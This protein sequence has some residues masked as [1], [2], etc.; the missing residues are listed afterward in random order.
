MAGIPTSIDKATNFTGPVGV[1]REVVIPLSALAST[2]N[3]PGFIA[4]APCF[5]ES[6]KV[7]NKDASPDWTIAVQNLGTDGL[8]TTSL[9]SGTTYDMNA[10]VAGVAASIGVNQNQT[11]AVGEALRFILT[12][13][14]DTLNG[15]IQIRYLATVG[16]V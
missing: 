12:R 9:L 6:I 3:F 4:P 2:A 11:M 10:L 1:Y 8:G 5:I 15:C 16:K 7:I 13:T 14:G